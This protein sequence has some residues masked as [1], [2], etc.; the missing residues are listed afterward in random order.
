MWR[1]FV[2]ALEV[3]RYA[4]ATGLS[5]FW[6]HRMMSVATVLTAAIM[7]LLF[8][9]FVTVVSHL[10]GT[11]EALEQKVNLIAYIR[12]DAAPSEV[13][14]VRDR[15]QQNP[16][17]LEVDFIS[18]DAAMQRLRQQLS[19]RQDL[20]GMVQGNPLPASLEVRLRDPG[21]M[22]ALARRLRDD[23]ALEEVAVQESVVD[24][25]VA[26]THYARTAGAVMVLSLGLVT[27]FIIVNTIR[28]AVYARRQE[29]EIMKLVGATDWFIRWPFLLEGVLD[30]LLGAV[31]AVAVLLLSYR[32]LLA[33]F[34]SLVTFLQLEFDPLFAPKLATLTLAVGIL[35]GGAG[36][37]ISV[38]RYLDI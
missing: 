37:Y 8:D 24:R 9:G 19:D 18:K 33:H 36:S 30:G 4:V 25:L 3:A 38:R 6:R 34:M 16:N 17:V 32:P 2:R 5:D 22:Q 21:G 13:L 15:L 27:L 12:D 31:A 26:L 14:A 10:G 11:L 20:L 28:L 23:P 7:L 35:V 29:I 1:L